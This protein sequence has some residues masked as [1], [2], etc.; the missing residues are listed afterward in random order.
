MHPVYTTN[1]HIPN[2]Y[3]TKTQSQAPQIAQK[4]IPPQLCSVPV[5][6]VV[7]ICVVCSVELCYLSPMGPEIMLWVIFLFIFLLSIT[8]FTGRA[9][10]SQNWS[11]T[12]EACAL[13]RSTHHGVRSASTSSN[14]IPEHCPQERLCSKWNTFYFM[15]M[16]SIVFLLMCVLY[17]AVLIWK[18]NLVSMTSCIKGK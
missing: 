9:R 16:F 13:L 10:I 4:N 1:I 6:K 15:I 8:R 5:C 7:C 14:I 11:L 3:N 2:M 17:C 12:F 18:R